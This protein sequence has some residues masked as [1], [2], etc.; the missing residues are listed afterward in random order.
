[1]KCGKAW[2]IFM[3]LLCD[4]MTTLPLPPFPFVFA[5]FMGR[6][7]QTYIEGVDREGD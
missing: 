4:R 2:V 7:S 3:H 6:E 1:M 5:V